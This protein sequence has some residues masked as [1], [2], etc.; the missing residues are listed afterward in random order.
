ME[1]DTVAVLRVI[2]ALACGGEMWDIAAIL[3]VDTRASLEP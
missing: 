1:A 3:T 2:I